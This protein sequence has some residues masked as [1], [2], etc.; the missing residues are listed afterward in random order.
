[1][2]HVVVAVGLQAIR[3]MGADGMRICP[4]QQNRGAHDT[5]A[6]VAKLS[7]GVWSCLLGQMRTP[8]VSLNLWL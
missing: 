5:V 3:F 8:S 7:C 2:C 1:M 4:N 6:H